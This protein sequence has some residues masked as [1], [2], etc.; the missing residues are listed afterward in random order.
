MKMLVAFLFLVLFVPLVVSAFSFETENFSVGSTN[1]GLS[2]SVLNSSDYEARSY[3]EPFYPGSLGDADEY[4]LSAGFFETNVSFQPLM[5][6]NLLSPPNNAFVKN[7][8]SFLY[9]V[10]TEDFVYSCNIRVFK[11]SV[12]LINDV[13]L[14]PVS[15]IFG[16]YPLSDGEYTWNVMCMRSLGNTATSLTRTVNMDSTPPVLEIIHPEDDS[17]PYSNFTFLI[18]ET[19]PSHLIIDV[20]GVDYVYDYVD[21]LNV[22][23]PSLSIGNYFYSVLV[24]DE[25]NNIVSYG[26]FPVWVNENP[27]QITGVAFDPNI[28]YENELQTVVAT[29][30]GGFSEVVVSL[31][32]NSTGWVNHTVDSFVSPAPLKY[33]YEINH[34]VLNRDETLIQKWYVLDDTDTWISS[35]EYSR[36]IRRAQSGGNQPIVVDPGRADVI[37]DVEEVE[38]EEE[39]EVDRSFWTWLIVL[40]VVFF[41]FFYRRKEEGEKE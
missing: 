6:V 33:F 27:V 39:F 10:V 29:I 2:G 36:V 14:A 25:A 9:E 23:S 12:L 3:S 15:G 16:P 4:V 30:T 41:L 11:D 35:D 18:N 40:L 7:N 1:V 13:D 5:V 22:F 28:V 34:S 17:E 32:T 37:D 19:N 21:G 20:N 24:F 38:E 26:P 31:F 8:A